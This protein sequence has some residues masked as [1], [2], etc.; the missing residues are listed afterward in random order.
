MYPTFKV[1]E[2]LKNPDGLEIT[3][4]LS[5]IYYKN[6]KW[7]DDKWLGF[8]KDGNIMIYG[9]WKE[10]DDNW[11]F[12]VKPEDILKSNLEVGKEYIVFEGYWGERVEI[13]IDENINWQKVV[14]T[15][16]DN[17]DH[18]FICWKTIS[19]FVNQNYMFGDQTIVCLECY[20]KFVKQCSFDFIGY[21]QKNKTQ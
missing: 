7:V 6:E 11:K 8:L 4:N 16:K 17:H 20:E 14:Y 13:V 9:R 18:C 10:S 12:F 21:P 5:S 3:G 2:I 1:T 15:S 19:E